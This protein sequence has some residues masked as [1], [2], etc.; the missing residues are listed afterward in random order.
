MNIRCPQCSSEA[1]NKYGSV[2]GGKQRYICLVCERQFVVNPDKMQFKN[3]PDCP[4]CGKPMHA[5]MKGP[6]YIRFRCSAYPKCRTFLKTSEA[7]FET[8]HDTLLS[9][10]FELQDFI[11]SIKGRPVW[12]VLCLTNNE[13]TAANRI[14]IIERSPKDSRSRQISA[15]IE[16]LTEFMMFLRSVTKLPRAS[17]KSNPLFWQYWDSIDHQ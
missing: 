2:G 16:Q 5:Y 3:R 17:Q 14:L 1:V 4:K 12:E 6:D 15:Y 11:R 10:D 7:E 13:A 8:M 9:G